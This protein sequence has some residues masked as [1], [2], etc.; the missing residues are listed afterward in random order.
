MICAKIL[1]LILTS[2]LFWYGGFK[3]HDAR[4]FIMPVILSLS[5]VWFVHSWWAL[6]ML[7]SIGFLTLGYGVKSPL[8]HC[9]GDGWGRGIWGLLAAL[10]FSLGLFLTHH[11]SWFFFVPYLALNFTLENALK[12]VNQL[13]GDPIIGTGFGLIVFLVHF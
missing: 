1:V 6:T 9:F 8:R 12:K 4:R 13:I 5:C 10:G 7:S 3:W 2:S 11:I